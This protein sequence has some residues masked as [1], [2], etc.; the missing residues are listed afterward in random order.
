[1][2]VGPIAR[3][4]QRYLRLSVRGL[5]VLVLV[6]GAG[7]G[8][9]VHS[10]RVQREAVAAIQRAEGTINYEWE[11]SNGKYIQ[12]AR[13][14]APRWLVELIGIDYFGHVT[15][16]ELSVSTKLTD[17]TIEQVGR[18][19]RLAELVLIES[20]FS[21]P[22]RDD[23]KGLTNPGGSQVTDASLVH[24]KAL[25]KLSSLT[26]NGSRFTDAGLVHLKGLSNLTSVDL[27]GTS[28]TDAG[29]QHLEGLSNLTFLDLGSTPITDAGLVHL[30]G[31]T[32]LSTLHLDGTRVTDAGLVRLKRLVK[33]SILWLAGTQVTDAAR[34]ELKQQMPGLTFVQ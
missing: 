28:M 20:P 11:L 24:L 13:P 27:R 32:K 21:D 14:C 16:V 4:W 19:T 8:W 5:I 18:L 29:L 26:L 10:A 23:T 2:P 7:L 6:I 3:S 34:Q 17:A 33:L 1:M 12:G 25:S 31:L 15:V 22:L 9:L 30:E